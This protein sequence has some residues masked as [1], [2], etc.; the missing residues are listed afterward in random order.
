MACTWSALAKSL[1]DPT[2]ALPSAAGTTEE[3]EGITVVLG[4]APTSVAVNTTAPVLLLTLDTG[5]GSADK[6]NVFVVTLSIV[7]V[8]EDIVKPVPA[9]IVA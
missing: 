3:A 8:P 2:A 5:A 4:K 9:L 6:V 7:A 1:L